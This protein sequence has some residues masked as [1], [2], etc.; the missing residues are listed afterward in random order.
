MNVL[1]LSDLY[2][3]IVSG[4]AREVQLLSERL[5]K[6]NHGVTVCTIG[7]RSSPK[8]R[9]ENGVKVYRLE[10][11][12]QKIPFLYKNPERRYHPPIADWLIVNQLRRIIRREKPEII[13]THG[14]ILYSVLPLR[15]K[16]DIPLIATFHT[17]GFICPVRMSRIYAGGICTKPLTDNCIKCGRNNYGLVKSFFV[18]YG[19]KSNKIFESNAIIFTNPNLV[20]KMGHLDTPKIYLGHPIDT[21]Y[22]KPIS[23]SNEYKNTILCWVK[24][25]E[26]K[27]VET[28]FEVAERM[29]E[30]EFDFVF[31]GER[32]THYKAI[33][34]NNV[35]LIPKPK[36]IP[37]LINK[38]PLILGQF[39][40]GVLGLSELEAMSC[41]KPVIAY[42]NRKYDVLY[43]S[44]CPI[45]SS[46]NAEEITNLIRL[47][48][49]NEDLG[50]LNRAWILENHSATKIVGKLIAI[51][52]NIA[53]SH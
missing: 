42:W 24:L 11:I 48:I 9:I 1:M 39:H 47:N 38:Y 7:S 4:H 15:K 36:E 31:V 32:K 44:P 35:N 50:R 8:F 45:V 23:S 20:E 51:Y 49:Q 25:D 12:F 29:P 30:Y 40:V 33:K 10:G 18:Y 53:R 6:K 19:V 21:D 28:I 13:H 34:P 16:I 26:S 14:W 22:Y 27:G 37:R 46:R 43:E 41:G 17:F 2:P 3:P 5:V 52:S